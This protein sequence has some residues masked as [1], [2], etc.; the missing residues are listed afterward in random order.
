[1]VKPGVYEL[2]NGI[3]LREIIY[4]HAGGIPH[5]HKLKAVVPGGIS[6]PVLTPDQI[7]VKMDFDSLKAIG[8]M[9][10]S[11]GIIVFHYT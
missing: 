1:M 11:G 3:T 6:A 7:D 2:P 5:G 4:D 8:S 9:A 10:G